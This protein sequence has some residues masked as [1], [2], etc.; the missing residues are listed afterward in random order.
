[1]IQHFWLKLYLY[2]EPKYLFDFMKF[3]LTFLFLLVV[4]ICYSQ[5]VDRRAFIFG[6]SLINHELAIIPPPSDENS[7]PH[8]VYLLAQEA[9]NTY[10]AGG[11]Y[12]FLPQHANLPPIAQWGFD[13]VPPV[14]DSDTEPF[15]DANID[16]TL[17][18]AG[19]FVQWQGPDIPY[20]GGDGIQS[21]LSA[22]VD[23]M[24]WVEGQEPGSR[25]YIYENWPD[26]APYLNSGFPPNATEWNNYNNYTVGAFHDWWIEYHDLLLQ[27]R[28]GLQAR[29]IPVGPIIVGLLNDTPL[30]TMAVTDLY[31]DDAPHG[32]PS[33]YFLAGLITYMAIYEEM[34]PSSFIVPP[35]V[36]PTLA[37][38]YNT[39]ANYIWTELLN[40]N[41][42]NG[43]SRVFFPATV[44]LEWLDIS[45][46][47][48]MYHVNINWSVAEEINVEGYDVERSVHGSGY[49]KIGERS[50][51][52][53]NHY[54]YVD[55]SA[56]GGTLYYRIKENSTDGLSN[57]SP[58][59]LVAGY[60]STGVKVYPNPS[61]GTISIEY[62]I[63]MKESI[64]LSIR[65]SNGKLIFTETISSEAINEPIS[66]NELEP[67]LYTLILR[68]KTY[69]NNQKL[70]ITR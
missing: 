43:D 34:A 21:P 65:S 56:P 23:I 1:M 10:S 28:P 70:I 35:T 11:Q 67:G 22:T 2:L 27:E 26:M 59:V 40:F 45:A 24:D 41:D 5:N 4:N 13:L 39:V 68:S 17:I 46:Q 55:V 37:S 44:P 47:R 29:M 61:K 32:L 38:H 31:E 50:V 6:H 30:S 20:F 69:V 8:W 54:S 7:V 36:H 48:Q 58:S 49:E 53:S 19:N 51:S 66:M 16:H 63:P 62:D 33:I 18:T 12:G 52:P 3:Q 14:W 64:D 9:G 25:V 57:Y 15:S 42:G 60:V